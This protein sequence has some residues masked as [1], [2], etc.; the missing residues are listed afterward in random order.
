MVPPL[1]RCFVDK[2]P[3]KSEF[4]RCQNNVGTTLRDMVVVVLLVEASDLRISG[5]SL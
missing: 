2:S 4:R 1:S 3:L 5:T